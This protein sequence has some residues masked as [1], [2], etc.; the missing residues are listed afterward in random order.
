MVG[1]YNNRRVWSNGGGK[2]EI[3]YTK[4]YEPGRWIVSNGTYHLLNDATQLVHGG[5]NESFP[6]HLCAHSV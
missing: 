5:V 2:L 6:G 4:R 1:T 3:F